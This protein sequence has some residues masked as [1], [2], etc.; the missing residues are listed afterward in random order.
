MRPTIR[1]VLITA[2]RDRLFLS[3]YGLLAVVLSVS[4]FT[5][6]GAIMEAAE[7]SLV[8]MAAGS[9]AVLV[10]GLVIFVA[11]HVE[12]MFESK[13][14]E[15]ILARTISRPKFIMAYWL[16][17][18]VVGLLLTLPTLSVILVFHL[19]VIGAVAWCISLALEILIVLAFTLFAAMT[20]E[21]AVPTVLATVGF[22]A[23][24]R[25]MSFITG[26]TVFHQSGVNRIINPYIEALSFALP[27]LDLFSQTQWL[28]YGPEQ[29]T[30]Y[31]IIVQAIVYVPLLLLAASHDL[32][33][34]VF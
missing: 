15:A 18:T 2:F 10:M 26:I 31:I 29:A 8:Y 3:L 5:G 33:K 21:K 25:L 22:Y 17:L 12:R 11:F 24:S 32:L 6:S 16:G 30:I 20:F 34:K 1:L 14:V 13:E 19:S 28:V 23:L 9:R 7:M 27:R 4:A